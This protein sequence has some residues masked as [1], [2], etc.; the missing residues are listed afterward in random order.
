MYAE[1]KRIMHIRKYLTK[2]E[3]WLIKRKTQEMFDEKIQNSIMLKFIEKM[4]QR[5]S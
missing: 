5:F 1:K 3:R 4:L 2:G